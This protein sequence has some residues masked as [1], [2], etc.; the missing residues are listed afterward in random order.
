MVFL[1][2]EGK[3]NFRMNQSTEEYVPPSS[4]L[5]CTSGIRE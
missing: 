3:E 5:L 1:G 2:G 4:V